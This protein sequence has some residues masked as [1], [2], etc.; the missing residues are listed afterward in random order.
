M[1]E[2]NFQSLGL[3]AAVIG[4]AMEVSS[5]GFALQISIIDGSY[6]KELRCLCVYKRFGHV[7]NEEMNHPSIDLD[8]RIL[9]DFF[10]SRIQNL[11]N[12]AV[13]EERREL[14]Q[15]QARLK[16][17]LKA[18]IDAHFRANQAPHAQGTVAELAAK[19]GV[20][21]S[22][23][24]RMKAAGT[25]DSWLANQQTGLQ[26]VADEAQA[27]EIQIGGGSQTA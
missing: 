1:S 25:L 19:F 15:Q 12:Q 17:E 6:D 9:K 10:R 18:E 14:E 23:I 21:K 22:E 26:G 27:D 13:M 4:K 3:A 7:N 20:S 11:F 2:L 8:L 5:D 16:I 24:R